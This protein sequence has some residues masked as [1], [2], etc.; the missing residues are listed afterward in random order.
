MPDFTNISSLETNSNET[1]CETTKKIAEENRNKSFSSNVY[2]PDNPY[3][4][5]HP[6]ALQKNGSPDDPTNYKG[7]GTGNFLD[8]SNGGGYYD[9]YGH[10]KTP[11]SGRN[12]LLASNRYS[13]TNQFKPCYD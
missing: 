9:I 11:N 8:T 13:P 1:S 4:G 5:L 3:T 7:K 12:A 10:P 6:N 2:S